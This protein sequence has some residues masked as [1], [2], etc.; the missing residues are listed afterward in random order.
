MT[1]P[2]PRRASSR[3]SSSPWR[4]R[5]WVA[6]AGSSTARTSRPAV[7]P[8]GS[9][10]GRRGPSPTTSLQRS[11]TRWTPLASGA[12][13]PRITGVERLPH[14]ASAPG[15]RW[16]A[17]ERASPASSPPADDALARGQTGRDA[18]VGDAEDEVGLGLRREAAGAGEQ[19][20]ARR[21]GWRAARRCGPGRARRTRRRAAAPAALPVTSV[22]TWCDASRSARASERC[23]PCEA[24]VR[25]GSPPMRSSTS[26]RCGPTVDTPRRTSSRRLAASAASR[27]ASAQSAA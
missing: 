19:R 16:A 2:G 26:S 13:S 8:E 27:P 23:S 24:C 17:G 1:R 4:N 6:M 3:A 10:A 14:R 15:S 25:A 7:D 12:P 9:G 5:T 21:A 18:A 20:L 11:N 22:I